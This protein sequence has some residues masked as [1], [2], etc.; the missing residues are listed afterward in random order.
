[1]DQ[2]QQIDVDA[3]VKRYRDWD[4]LQYVFRGIKKFAPWIHKVYLITNGQLPKWFNTQNEKLVVVN[5]KDYIPAEYLP[6]FCCSPIE[7]NLHRVSNLS[8]HFVYMNDDFFFLKPLK[9][10]DFFTR[11]G[12]PKIVAM[13]KPNCVGFC[14]ANK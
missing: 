10:T 9:K 13:E 1:M 11:N 3:N 5:H 7:L 4:N 8:E 12:L 2:E 6:T 14:H